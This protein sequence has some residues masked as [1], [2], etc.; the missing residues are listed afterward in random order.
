M[1]TFHKSLIYV[2]LILLSMNLHS[3]MI[4]TDISGTYEESVSGMYY[5]IT[6]ND[7]NTFLFRYCNATGLHETDGLWDWCVYGRTIHIESY[8]YDVD[9][10]NISYQTTPCDIEYHVNIKLD[11]IVNTVNYKWYVIDKG[12]PIPLSY[13]DTLI[14]IERHKKAVKLVGIFNGNNKYP[15]EGD[16]LIYPNGMPK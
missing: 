10:F 8:N 14:R 13:N 16:C 15:A 2:A 4:V 9:A 12:V 7:D 3:C 6:I 11:S 1:K 5:S